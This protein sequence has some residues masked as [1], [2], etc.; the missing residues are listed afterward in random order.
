MM[1]KLNPCGSKFLQ[2]SSDLREA[3]EVIDHP[4]GVEEKG[5]RLHSRGSVRVAIKR[6]S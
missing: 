1:L 2:S 4:I 6:L 3:I 5:K